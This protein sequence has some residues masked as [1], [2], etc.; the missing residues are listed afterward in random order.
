MADRHPDSE[1]LEPRGERAAPG[2]E[3]VETYEVE[4]GVV[5]YDAENPLAWVEAE[6]AVSL[7]DCA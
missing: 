6:A 1:G 3:T 4:D 2:T 7:S 5:L